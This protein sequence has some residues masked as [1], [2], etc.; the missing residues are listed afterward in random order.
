MVLK[1]ANCAAQLDFRQSADSNCKKISL[2]VL[3]Q[4]FYNKPPEKTMLTATDRL[5]FF[6]RKELQ[7]QKIT[8]LP[9][10]I[11]LGSKGYVDYL[12]KKDLGLR[13]AD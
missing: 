8:G 7:I 10:Y 12:E 9:L 4:K 13:V 11:R 5:G 6:C 1:S 3:P 2:Q